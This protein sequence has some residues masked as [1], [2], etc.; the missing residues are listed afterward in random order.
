VKK[1]EAHM[2]AV[3]VMIEGLMRTQIRSKESDGCRK[4]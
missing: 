4:G 1:F 3:H 2:C